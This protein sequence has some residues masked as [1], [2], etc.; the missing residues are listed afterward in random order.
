MKEEQIAKA[1]ERFATS[2][3]V[4]SILWIG[5]WVSIGYL[6]VKHLILPIF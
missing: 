6:T 2:K 5:M 4:D 3:K 1:V